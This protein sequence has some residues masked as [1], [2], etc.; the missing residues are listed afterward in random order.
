M[1]RD[2]L[3]KALRRGDLRTDSSPLHAPAPAPWDAPRVHGPNARPKFGNPNHPKPFR[4]AAILLVLAW[5]LP[6]L[7][8]PPAAPRIAGPDFSRE[9]LP[10]LSDHCFACHGPDE[11]AR[12][13]GLRL[14]TREGAL[15]P[16]D[17]G[18][19]AVVP[20]HP[21]SS[22]L[23]SRITAADPD[24]RMPPDRANKPLSQE[25]VALLSRWIE[26]GAPWGVHWAYSPPIRP[27]PPSVAHLPEVGGSPTASASESESAS[28]IA[29]GL[30]STPD[31]HPID[32]FI[33]D[34]LKRENLNP[35][36]PAAP[37]TLVRRVTLDLTGIPP[38]PEE[39]DAYLADSLP[40]A[41]D[42]LVDRLLASPRYGERMAWEWL[43]AARYADSNGYQGDS[44]RTMWP[45]RDWV[46][47]A[48]N[49][50][51]PFDTFST[52]QI[53]GDL[54]PDATFEQ[55]LATGFIRNH[56]I[57]GEG[58]RIP[59]ENR[60]D[61]LFDQT[62]TVGT[63]WLGATLNCTRCH[64]HKFDPLTQRD[65]FGLL[66]YFNRTAVD[67]SGGDP[68]SRPHLEVPTPDQS[69][70]RETAKT[71]LDASIRHLEDLEAVKF[72]REARQPASASPAARDLPKE[73]LDH[74]GLAPQARDGGR[75]EKLVTYWK[76][77]DPEYARILEEQRAARTT[78]DA[79]VRSI[80][81]VMILEDV[82]NPRDTFILR[83]GIYTQPG[84]KILAALP[85]ALTPFPADQ[86]APPNRLTLARW[87]FSPRHPLTARVAVNRY[88]QTFFGV[89]LVKTSEDFGIQGEKPS[90]PDL[91]DWLATDFVD[92]GWNVKHLHRLIVTSAAYRRS[93]ITDPTRR[94]RDP[95]NRLLARGP[96][97]RMP[98]WMI[99]D[100][101]LAAS[102]LLS[103]IR[104]GPPV[105]PYQPA[106]VWEE[107]TF[108]NKRYR[109]DQGT[110]LY[111]RSLYV[112]WRRI[113]A[114][115]MFFDVANRQTCSVRAPRTNVPLHALLT[116]NDDTYVE[117]ARAL[118]EHVLLGS[119]ST[120]RDRL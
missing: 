114:P 55:R 23:I 81:R 108:G 45:W 10:I 4:A 6:A 66:A 87:L 25:Q 80:P 90:H 26:A 17:G 21:D 68:Q 92:S 62:E 57:N 95:E 74:L 35:T 2:S 63:V 119:P 47:D 16:A 18:N 61:Y 79:V 83:R 37:E 115:T 96:R 111:R 50:N 52:W 93:S 105:K 24:E 101:A 12:K 78:H 51:L 76:P 94:D 49:R 41:W 38:T 75:L 13:G 104:G 64:D 110:A 106:G 77:L 118:A 86:N 60:I 36:P 67:G 31:P 30:E 44:D 100:S 84:E 19:P 1:N 28:P 99:R 53:A 9:I 22:G 33:L 3:T 89:G 88:W 82:P 40:G 8:N 14:D 43:D 72:P 117:A 34:R 109:Q 42:R 5:G 29:I 48:L 71:A 69:Q 27:S 97:F 70:R 56:M 39:I 120:T 103:E 113:V 15:A 59:E 46:V 85:P 54:L 11:K 7:G 116:L 73:I 58:G 112:F 102:G 107:A 20:H 32:A 98:S 65:Y 91:L